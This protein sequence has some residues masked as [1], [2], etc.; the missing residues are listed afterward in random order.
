MK[1]KSVLPLA[2]MCLAA[3][4]CA[5]TYTPGDTLTVASDETVTVTDA[6]IGEFN[7]LA[8]VTFADATGVLVFNTATPPTVPISGNGTIRKT[9]SDEWKI[10]VSRTAF[11][12]TWDFVGGTT[13]IT[14]RYALTTEDCYSPVYVRSGATLALDFTLDI[15]ASRTP[16]S[17]GYYRTLHL[18]GTGDNGVGALRFITESGTQGNKLRTIELD[19]DATI[20]FAAGKYLYQSSGIGSTTSAVTLNGHTLTMDGR[21]GSYWYLVAGC[22]P[23]PGQIVVTNSAASGACAFSPRGVR[24]MDPSLEIVLYDRANIYVYNNWSTNYFATLT[25]EGSNCAFIH[26]HQYKDR[27]CSTGA[28]DFWA[29]EVNLKNAT[30]RLNVGVKRR[31]DDTVSI[32][33]RTGIIGPVTGPGSL[34]LAT[35]GDYKHGTCYLTC[36]TNSYTGATVLDGSSGAM[37]VL[38]YSNC[39]PVYAN[40]Q[41]NRP[42]TLAPSGEEYG[43]DASSILR[44]AVA[45]TYT[46]PDN[47]RSRRVVVDAAA[48]QGQS[49]TFDGLADELTGNLIDGV[50]GATGTALTFRSPL[51]RPIQPHAISNTVTLAGTAPLTVTNFTFVA[52]QR[53]DGDLVIDGAKDLQLTETYPFYISDGHGAKRV[54][55]TNSTFTQPLN[56]SKFTDF[57]STAILLGYRYGVNEYP[58]DVLIGEGTVFTGRLHVASGTYTRGR[59]VQTGGDVAVLSC[60]ADDSNSSSVSASERCFGYYD[61]VDGK[62]T[63]LGQLLLGRWTLAEGVIRQRGG[64]FKILRHPNSTSAATSQEAWLQLG[65]GGNPAGRGHYMATGG[66]AYFS[67][68]IL[69]DRSTNARGIFTV[70]GDAV[71]SAV[72]SLNF[73]YGQGARAIVNLNDNGTLACGGFGSRYSVKDYIGDGSTKNWLPHL[74]LNANGGRIRMNVSSGSSVLGAADF[75]TNINSTAGA[76]IDRIALYAKGLKIDVT[77]KWQQANGL[78][79]PATGKGVA[80]IPWTRRERL[81]VSPWVQIDGDGDGASAI[82][83]VDPETGDATGITITS[84]GCDYTWATATIYDGFDTV[85]Q[86]NRFKTVDCTLAD[87]D[88]SGGLTVEGTSGTLVLAATNTYRG[89]TVLNGATL[90]LGITNAI[91]VDSTIVLGGGKLEMNGKTLADGSTKPKNWAVD[92]DRVREVGTV[93][94]NWNLAFPEGATFTVL[95]ASELMDADKAITTLLYVNG[96]VTGAPEIQGVTDPR[97]KVAWNGNRLALRYLRGMVMSFR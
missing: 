86:T 38:P 68:A 79:T 37:F 21:N 57:S 61:L 27:A 9:S 58:G 29:G 14:S 93:T 62:L 32:D 53:S 72:T 40:A 63:Y 8:S 96:T 20:S 23:G 31:S 85:G 65:Y 22:V 83:D 50:V 12:G 69:L 4:S 48:L 7:T 97:W 15:A 75:G 78:I 41:F 54:R 94:N 33:Y 51:G 44:F 55:L 25:V 26:E 1:S 87:N 71:V 95:N 16:F 45:A 92:M 64:E 43:W 89:P 70:G 80:S 24:L 11:N 34:G 66:T 35:Y 73:G 13:V 46:G 39:I 81:L 19:A 60:F 76:P 30:S 2:A 42:L 88:G 74:F 18:A 84:P 91:P 17:F 5:A 10:G 3:L 77:D 28:S 6:D 52:G 47:S 56:T 82:V 49:L 36:P 67:G 90:S 59:V